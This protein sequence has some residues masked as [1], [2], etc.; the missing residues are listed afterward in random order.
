MDWKIGKMDVD[1]EEQDAGDQE[2]PRC[3]RDLVALVP[4]ARALGG[5]LRYGRPDW[6]MTLA[7]PRPDR[8]KKSPAPDRDPGQGFIR[9]LL[10]VDTLG[11]FIETGEDLVE[12]VGL[13]H[14]LLQAFH[15]DLRHLRRGRRGRR[16]A[17]RPPGLFWDSISK[18]SRRNLSSSTGR[19]RVHRKL[20]RD[21][22]PLLISVLVLS[23]EDDEFQERLGGPRGSRRPT[24]CG[25]CRSVRP[26]PARH[27]SLMAGELVEVQL[28][29]VQGPALAQRGDGEVALEDGRRIAPR[30]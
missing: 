8:L 6:S 4:R 12:V 24:G 27:P 25:T 22:R 15:A 5:G 23:A 10:V 19:V 11:R 16:T 3:Q 26:R 14:E 1:E 21:C 18:P 9:D 17:P 2:Q 20:A 13:D 30:R 29:V 7:S 28:V